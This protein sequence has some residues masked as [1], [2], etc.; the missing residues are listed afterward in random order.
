M[1]AYG[2]FNIIQH[3]INKELKLKFKNILYIISLFLF[4]IYLEIITLNF[5]GLDKNTNFEISKRAR[6]NVNK[7][8]N[9]IAEERL[10]SFS[11]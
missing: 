8:L 3:I 7:E 2:T 6:K 5:C 9:K 4:C 1:I 11:F 10:N